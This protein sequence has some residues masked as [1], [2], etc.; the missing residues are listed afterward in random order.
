MKKL[1]GEKKKWRTNKCEPN[2]VRPPILYGTP[3]AVPASIGL[4][5]CLY[6]TYL[7]VPSSVVF[8]IEAEIINAFLTGKME[9]K[10]ELGTNKCVPYRIGCVPNSI[11][12]SSCLY[13]THLFVPSSVVFAIL[14]ERTLMINSPT[15]LCEPEIL[16]KMYYPMPRSNP[17]FPS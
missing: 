9:N 13:G 4:P 3:S 7:F 6:G 16:F 5:P 12:L 1:F 14:P 2:F 8:Y 11:R 15:R 17:N 10:T